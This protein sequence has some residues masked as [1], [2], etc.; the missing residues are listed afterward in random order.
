MKNKHFT[1]IGLIFLVV[2]T[3]ITTLILSGFSNFRLTGSVYGFTN[4]EM[5]F[6]SK[7]MSSKRILSENFYGDISDEQIYDGAM[8]GMLETTGKIPGGILWS[9]SKRPA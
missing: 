4:E 2:I 6:I 7:L 8:S 3:S 1:F 9:R 5:E